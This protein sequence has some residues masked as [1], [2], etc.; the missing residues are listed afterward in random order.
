M[1]LRA[2]SLAALAAL[3]LAAPVRADSFHLYSYDPADASTRQ[4]AGPLTFTFR[5]GLLHITVLGLMS[6]VA[7]AKASLRPAD[8]RAL[9]PGGLPGAAGA[10]SA[11]DR[12]LYEVQS[13]DEGAALISAFCPGA[14]RAWL[15]FSPLKLNRDLSVLV[16]GSPLAGGPARLCR[17]LAFRFHGEWVLPPGR[18]I[19]PR[20]LEF[21]HYPGT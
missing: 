21:G 3:S 10:A 2:L 12:E 5:K 19:D 9:G 18:A 14:G 15:A 13:A 11:R 17:R 8:E 20:D 7:Q 6:T 16:L 1:R 4:A